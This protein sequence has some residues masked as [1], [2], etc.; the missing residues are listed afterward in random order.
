MRKYSTD[1]SLLLC[2]QYRSDQ[3]QDNLKRN[4]AAN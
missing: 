3:V 2:S 4:N 1:Y